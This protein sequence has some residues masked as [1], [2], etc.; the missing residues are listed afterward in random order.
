MKILWVLYLTPNIGEIPT[1]SC[2]ST[3]SLLLSWLFTPI[4]TLSLEVTDFRENQWWLSNIMTRRKGG[5]SNNWR[6]GFSSYG[7][8]SYDGSSNR[9]C[10]NSR[11]GWKYLTTWHSRF[12][13]SER[14]HFRPTYKYCS[15]YILLTQFCKVYL[16]YT[17]IFESF[18]SP[19]DILDLTKTGP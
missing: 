13:L 10:G 15:S 12:S 9:E 18:K 7:L 6:L 5:I 14:R 17:H 3:K 19:F 11:Y 8:R 1:P 16:I 4:L 2:L